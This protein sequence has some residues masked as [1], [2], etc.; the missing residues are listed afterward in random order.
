LTRY[1]TD[2]LM[3]APFVTLGFTTLYS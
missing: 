2:V 1:L 3:T